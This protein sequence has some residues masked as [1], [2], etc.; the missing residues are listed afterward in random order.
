MVSAFKYK[1]CNLNKHYKK[2]GLILLF[3]VLHTLP[4]TLIVAVGT[5][6]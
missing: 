6:N 1:R 4:K 2:K 3:G 5:E